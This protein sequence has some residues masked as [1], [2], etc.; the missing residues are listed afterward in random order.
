MARSTFGGFGGDQVSLDPAGNSGFY[1]AAANYNAIGTF[2]SAATGGTKYTD[3][4]DPTT[5]VALAGVSTDAHGHVIPFKGPDGIT[6]GWLDFGG[7]RFKVTATDSGLFQTVT[8]LDAATAPLFGS[9]T[10]T[11]GATDGRYTQQAHGA[12]NVLDKGAAGNGTID[13]TAAIQSAINTAATLGAG[14]YFPQGTYLVSK[15]TGLDYMLEAKAGGRWRGEGTIKV[16]STVGDYRSVVAG[17]STSTDLTGLTIRDLTFDMNNTGN[18]VVTNANLFAGFPRYAVYAPVG[19]RIDVSRNTFKDIDSVNTVVIGGSNARCQD[20]TFTGVG[21]S[22]TVHDHSTIYITADGMTVTGNVFEGVASGKGA[23]TAIETHGAG[24]IS[25]NRVR[26]YYNGANITGITANGTDGCIVADNR[27]LDVNNGIVLW[28]ATSGAGLRQCTVHDNVVIINHDNWLR[29]TTDY[30]RG[31]SID[32][33]INVDIESLN[34]HD[35]LIWYKASVATAQSGELQ[36]AGIALWASSTTPNLKNVRVDSNT[37][38]GSLSTGIRF[39]ATA[40]RLRIQGNDLINP[41]LSTDG[42]MASFYKSGITLVGALTDVKVTGNRTYDTQATHT[43]AYGIQTSLTSATRCVEGDNI[44]TCTDGTALVAFTQTS[45]QLFSVL[46]DVPVQSRFTT[47]LYYS[48]QGGRGTVATVN[49]TGTAAPFWVSAPSKFDRIGAQVTVAGTAGTVV[50]LGIYAD[51]G[52]GTPGALVLDAGTIAGD[53]VASAEIVISP[54][55]S[56]GLY[57][58]VAV[59]QGGT[60]TMT[61]MSGSNEFGAGST[62][63]VATGTAPRSGFTFTAAGALPSTFS[64]AGQTAAAVIVALRAA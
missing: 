63:A 35:N 24:V 57:W 10:S 2:W 52:N 13:D 40:Q 54:T 17:V 32:P 8:G 59:S 23:T 55:L 5:S 38:I 53:A 49:G 36:A 19:S 64:S 18:P 1:K 34:I 50:R 12:I 58:L 28:S 37:I 31:I 7:G 43:L 15:P 46:A 30:P 6:E 62:L 48:P 41:G 27:F 61:C 44:V 25:G 56:A 47:S 11:R 16:S 22:G 26:D 9:A 29:S 4:I 42:T 51:N 45:G 39:A 21:T 3:L 14:V 60:P 33:G 20:N